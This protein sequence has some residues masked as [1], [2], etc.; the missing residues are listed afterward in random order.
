MLKV[1]QL[2]N[3]GKT[4]IFKLNAFIYTIIPFNLIFFHSYIEYFS[5]YVL[6]RAV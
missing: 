2:K 5:G 3:A 1:N 6:Y 4:D